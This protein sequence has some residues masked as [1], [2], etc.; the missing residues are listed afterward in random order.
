MEPFIRT[1]APIP[2]TTRDQGHLLVTVMTKPV[3]LAGANVMQQEVRAD[4]AKKLSHEEHSLSLAFEN[5]L[6]HPQ[7]RLSSTG[8]ESGKSWS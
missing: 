7:D 3:G 6:A 4:G 8:T 2:L 1:M 5:Y